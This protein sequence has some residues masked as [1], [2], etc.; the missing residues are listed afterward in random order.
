MSLFG[1]K[2]YGLRFPFD[3]GA[4][5]GSVD[6]QPG[7]TESGEAELIGQSIRIILGTPVGSRVMNRD[8]GSRLEE[9]LFEPNDAI[10]DI[11]LRNAVV[12]A[13]SKFEPRVVINQVL[14]DRSQNQRAV[15]ITVEYTIIRT[16]EQSQAEV[17]FFPNE[18]G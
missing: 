8:F 18:G 5:S 11:K 13:I 9:L 10:L 14:I 12:E 16:R 6:I 15:T 2:Q 7:D 4:D 17:Q 1:K 3:I